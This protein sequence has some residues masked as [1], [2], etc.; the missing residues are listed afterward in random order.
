MILTQD[1]SMLEKRFASCQN[2]GVNMER[3]GMGEGRE[4]RQKELASRIGTSNLLT[5]NYQSPT[6][7]IFQFRKTQIFL[8]M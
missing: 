7:K 1:L 2:I 6:P 8:L 3:E 5:S 4:K